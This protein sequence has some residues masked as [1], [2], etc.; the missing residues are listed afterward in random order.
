M[1][2]TGYF[3][4]VGYEVSHISIGMIPE[5]AELAG[6]FAR[7]PAGGLA[8]LPWASVLQEENKEGVLKVTSSP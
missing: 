3:G 4:L 5:Y 7:P 6:V 1:W 2:E 8:H